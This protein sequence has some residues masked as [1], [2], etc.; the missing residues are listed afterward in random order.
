MIKSQDLLS[1]AD[2]CNR[3]AAACSDRLIAEKL[4][5]LAQ[6][7]W[8]M[9]GQPAVCLQRGDT[10]GR[11]IGNFEDARARANDRDGPG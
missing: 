9:A 10:F 6:D 4:R 7:Y 1:H 5:Q 11:T 8:E 2:R 3:L